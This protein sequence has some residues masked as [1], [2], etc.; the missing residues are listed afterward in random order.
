MQRE[1]PLGWEADLGAH[2][3][4]RP[5]LTDGAA[6]ARSTDRAFPRLSSC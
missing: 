2:V 6:K 1:G 4:S 3:S 5:S